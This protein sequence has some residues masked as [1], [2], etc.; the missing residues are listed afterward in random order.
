MQRNQ[1]YKE[2]VAIWGYN[3][4]NIWGYEGIHIPVGLL[5]SSTRAKMYTKKVSFLQVDSRD[6]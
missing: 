5:T 3:E 2:G 4:A 1:L 6:N